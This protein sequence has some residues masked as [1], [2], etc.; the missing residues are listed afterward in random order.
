MKSQYE[1]YIKHLLPLLETVDAFHLMKT[2]QVDLT[3]CK[4]F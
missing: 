4:G 1:F 2:S 3:Y